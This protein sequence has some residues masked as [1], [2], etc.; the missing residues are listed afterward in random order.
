MWEQNA[1]LTF[2]GMSDEILNG[3]RSREAHSTFYFI[4]FNKK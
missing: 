1:I 3:K 4:Y 2:P